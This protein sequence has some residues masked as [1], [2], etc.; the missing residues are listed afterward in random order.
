MEHHFSQWLESN[1]L[2]T[3]FVTHAGDGFYTNKAKG[4]GVIRK[5]GEYGIQSFY[6]DDIVGFQ[7]YDDE[8]LV[9]EWYVNSSWRI[10]PRCT[11]HSTSEV[12]MKLH[13]KNRSVL[14]LQIF[15]ATRGN[16]NRNSSNHVDLMNYACQIAQIIYSFAV[17]Q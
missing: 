16:V 10:M 17:S 3:A 9:T 12:Y 15:R 1:D 7:V 5:K 6:L 11:H 14:R 13:M 8:N 2:T 4:H